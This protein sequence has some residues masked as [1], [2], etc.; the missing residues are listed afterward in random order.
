M[1]RNAQAY[2]M[3]LCLALGLAAC[4]TPSRMQMAS[5]S[6]EVV[7]VNPDFKVDAE[8]GEAGRDLFV[9]KGCQGCHTVGKGR[10]AGPDLFGVTELRSIDWLK[11]F[12]KNTGEMLDT[13]PLAQGLLKQYHNVRMPTIRMSDQEIEAIIHYMQL[14]TNERR[15]GD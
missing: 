11:A 8:L 2:A 6:G 13:D 10:A 3:V 7:T 4:S 1:T 12:L 14:R 9:S 15:S 5:N